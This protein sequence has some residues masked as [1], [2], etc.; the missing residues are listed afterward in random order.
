MSAAPV[1]TTV[2]KEFDS[3]KQN[4][5]KFAELPIYSTIFD[6]ENKKWGKP[7]DYYNYSKL[8]R[9]SNNY[10][11][12]YSFLPSVSNVKTESRVVRSTLEQGIKVVRECCFDCVKAITDKKKPIDVFVTTGLE[13][14]QC[15]LNYF[16]LL[17]H[18]KSFILRLTVAIDFLNQPSNGIHRTGAIAVGACA[19]YIISIRRGFIRRLLYTSIGGLGVASICYPKEAETYWHQALN[20]TKTCA[21]I[22]YNFAYGG[23]YN[24]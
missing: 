4:V 21:T 10:I 11:I 3:N 19:G 2:I 6:E 22:L 8:F 20:E 12:L 9:I 15:R 23:E 13:H 14:S 1:I 24:K 5:L 7:I 16:Q 17:P 18:I